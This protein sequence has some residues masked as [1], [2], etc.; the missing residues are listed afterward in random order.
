MSLIRAARWAAGVSTRAAIDLA[1]CTLFKIEKMGE[2][3]ICSRLY[4]NVKDAATVASIFDKM[5][6]S[7]NKDH[8]HHDNDTV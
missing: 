7:E 4:D 2:S 6:L 5:D 1:R 8:I 3:H